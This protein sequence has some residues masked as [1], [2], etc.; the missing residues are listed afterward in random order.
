MVRA[1][2]DTLIVPGSGAPRVP[3]RSVKGSRRAGARREKAGE[4]KPPSESVYSPV[5]QVTFKWDK[6]IL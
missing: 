5:L 1:L 3:L 6:I 2:L 4:E